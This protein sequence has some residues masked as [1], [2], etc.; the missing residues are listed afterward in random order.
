MLKKYEK[1]KISGEKIK[2]FIDDFNK[3]TG[4]YADF[5]FDEKKGKI[6]YPQEKKV[7]YDLIGYFDHDI[8]E[9][10]KK[11]VE[12]KERKHEGHWPGGW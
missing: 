7:I 11:D 5:T 4:G 1:G 9:W 12:V 10:W 8:G 6:V 2:N 3:K